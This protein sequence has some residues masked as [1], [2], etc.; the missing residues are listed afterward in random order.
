MTRSPTTWAPKATSCS[1]NRRRQPE[2]SGCCPPTRRDEAESLWEEFDAGET[3][4]A[5]FANAVDRLLPVLHNMSNGGGTWREHSVDMAAAERRLSPIGDGSEVLWE[6]CPGHVGQRRRARDDPAVSQ[7]VQQIRECT[8]PA[9]RFRFP[10]AAGERLGDRCPWCGGRTRLVY[11]LEEH[12]EATRSAQF[13]S[14]PLPSPPPGPPL[15]ALLDNVRSLYNVG[16]IFRSADAAGFSHLYLCGVTPTPDNRKL[17]KTSLGAERSVAWSHHRN[18]VDLAQALL[19]GGHAFWGL[20]EGA[21][22]ED[23]FAVRSLPPR[24]VLVVGSEVTGVDLDLLRLCSRTVGIP[25]HG[26]KR[27]LN[28]ATAF[29]VA[30]VWL[31]QTR[32]ATRLSAGVTPGQI[33][34]S[35]AARI[36]DMM[37]VDR[38]VRPYVPGA[39]AAQEVRR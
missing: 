39:A 25:M 13:A 12:P 36:R 29:G 16:A 15:A 28:V 38:P 3:A 24:L 9:C 34:A 32:C 30:A 23:L 26:H 19:A 31:R 10:M 20:E 22:A 33:A 18:A 17:A 14:D 4:A 27:S 7:A 37:G 8:E 1:G 2:S 35:E 21:P 11:A 5:R 6:L